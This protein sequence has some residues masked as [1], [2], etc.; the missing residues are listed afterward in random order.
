MVNSQK[1]RVLKD[2]EKIVVIK[3]KVARVVNNQG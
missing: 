1:T 2:R 3:S